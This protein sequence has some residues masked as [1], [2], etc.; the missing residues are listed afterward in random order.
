MGAVFQIVMK[1]FLD[2]NAAGH[3]MALLILGFIYLYFKKSKNAEFI[4]AFV[5]CLMAAFLNPWTGNNLL[6]FWFDEKNYWLVFLSIP[7]IPICAFVASEVLSEKKDMKRTLLLSVV[8][9]LLLICAGPLFG[10][11]SELQKKSEGYIPEEYQMFVDI[12]NQSDG[13]KVMA[14]DEF[15]SL[16]RA[17]NPNIDLIYEVAVIN[18]DYAKDYY[19]EVVC[20]AHKDMQDPV[21]RLG[22]ITQVA[23][24]NV[25]NYI[26]IPRE[27]DEPSSMEYAGYVSV[28][29]NE[30]YILYYYQF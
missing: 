23:I 15:L 22:K 13:A 9:I 1:S 17:E 19:D 6:S 25:C 8:G 28:A 18:S 30:K 5:L 16:L 4:I 27:A 14:S 2:V 26:L 24:G 10:E 21:D 29:E 12:L 3:V 11:E 7:A 20:M